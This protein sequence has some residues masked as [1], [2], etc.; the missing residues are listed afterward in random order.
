MFWIPMYVLPGRD[1]RA[2]AALLVF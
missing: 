2:R 1:W